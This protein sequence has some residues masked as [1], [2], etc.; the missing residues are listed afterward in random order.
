MESYLAAYDANMVAPNQHTK[1]MH[2]LLAWARRIDDRYPQKKA[3][4]GTIFFVPSTRA[5]DK[6]RDMVKVFRSIHA[7]TINLDPDTYLAQGMSYVGCAARDID[8]RASAHYQHSQSQ[9]GANYTWW[10]TMSCIKDMGLSPMV[11]IVQAIRTWEPEQL[12]MSELLVTLLSH[13]M[14]EECGFNAWPPGTTLDNNSKYHDWNGDVI[15]TM[16]YRNF[17]FDQ[18]KES[19]EG[20]RQVTGDLQAVERLQKKI[21]AANVDILLRINSVTGTGVLDPLDIDDLQSTVSRYK[22]FIQSL[23]AADDNLQLCMQYF[24]ELCIDH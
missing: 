10:L 7:S 12:P 8:D 4:P 24:A 2:D 19:T 17:L 23:K 1:P 18:I 6:L 9:H 14:M 21:R 3:K 13:S 5:L 22:E 15:D 16:H 11:R 20:L